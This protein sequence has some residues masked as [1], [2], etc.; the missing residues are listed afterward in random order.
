MMTEPESLSLCYSKVIKVF[1]PKFEVQTMTGEPES[2]M[3]MS[4]RSAPLLWCGL[5]FSNRS[6]TIASH[7]YHQPPP[8]TQPDGFYTN[9]F[10]C[11]G[12]LVSIRN[13]GHVDQDFATKHYREI[14]RTKLI[15]LCTWCG[16]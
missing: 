3:S 9:F 2:L 6:P 13:V 14:F 10:A 8:S 5:R 1:T 11:W 7:Q 15:K 12:S 4:L 16:Q